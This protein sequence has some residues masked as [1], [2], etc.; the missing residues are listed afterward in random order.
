MLLSEDCLI[1]GFNASEKYRYSHIVYWRRHSAQYAIFISL[2]YATHT[3]GYHVAASDSNGGYNW[4]LCRCSCSPY[5][6]TFPN[7]F[8]LL[9]RTTRRAMLRPSFVFSLPRAL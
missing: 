2:R 7:L 1:T 4:A 5:V 6:R 9:R 8:S 3:Q